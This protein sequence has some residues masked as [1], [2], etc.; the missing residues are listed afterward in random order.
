MSA[1]AATIDYLRTLR[2]GQGRLS[3]AAFNV[4]PWQARFVRGALAPGVVES[5]LTLG[6]GG[7]KST[8][9]S[10]IGCSALAGPLVQPEAEILIVASSH[11]QGQVI[12]RHVQRFLAPGIEAGDFRVQDSTNV[13]RIVNRATG[14]LLTV[15]GSDPR[16]LHGAAPSLILADELAQWPAPR[17]GEMLAALRTAMGKIP[18]GR[19]MLIGTRP[20][21]SDHAFA[22]ALRDSDYVQVH[23]AGADD[24]PFQRR[25]WAKANPSLPAMPDLAAAIAREAKAAKRDPALL[26]SFRALRLNMGVEDTEAAVLLEAATWAAIEGEADRAGPCVWGVDLGSSAA[27]SSVAAYLPET[28]RLEAIAAFPS[29]PS[30]AERGVRDGVAGLYKQCAVR[31]ELIVCGGAAVDVPALIAEALRRFGRPS[32]IAADRWREGELRD[33]LDAA[34]VPARGPFVSWPRF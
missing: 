16:R 29:E 11:D 12:F 28:G 23:A 33:A 22:A 6:R 7:G 31:G 18:D 34:A 4:L 1:A 15:K 32:A 30:L 8:L 20:A 9:I 10:A 13:S 3:G 5:S 21:G 2:I 27:Q 19:M 24:P 17:I 25:I 26:A 14:T